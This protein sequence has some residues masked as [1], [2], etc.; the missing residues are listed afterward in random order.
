MVVLETDGKPSF[1]P[2]FCLSGKSVRSSRT[3]WAKIV[4]LWA[5]P[6]RP[7][8]WTWTSRD[9]SHTSGNTHMLFIQYKWTVF[10]RTMFPIR[11]HSKQLK[12]RSV[13]GFLA[14]PG[15]SPFW[16]WPLCHFEKMQLCSL[17]FG[18]NDRGGGNSSF[19]AEMSH[20]WC[21]SLQTHKVLSNLQRETYCRTLSREIRCELGCINTVM[22]DRTAASFWQLKGLGW[23]VTRHSTLQEP[24]W[25]SYRTDKPVSYC[26][27]NF[28]AIYLISYLLQYILCC[29]PAVLWWF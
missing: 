7:P 19:L 25:G 18:T 12:L 24:V 26:K 20:P 29:Y 17:L 22:T 1:P 23:E 27:M 11:I 5:P 8:S 21:P 9:T 15:C 14:E 13:Y 4:L 3:Y 10:L 28:M 6:D 16:L 2:S